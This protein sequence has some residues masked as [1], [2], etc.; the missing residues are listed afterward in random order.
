MRTAEEVVNEIHS[1][2]GDGD[3]QGLR[4][5]AALLETLQAW[6]VCPVIHAAGTN[7]KGSVCAMLNSVLTAAGYRTGMYTSPFLQTYSER[8]RLNGKPITQEMLARYG[9]ETLDAAEKLKREK[10]YHCTPFE[11]GTALAFNTFRAE[12]AELIISETGMGGRLDPTNAVPNPAVCAI[13]AIGMDHM[14]YLGHTL[15]AIA[16]E[17]AGIIKHGVPVVCYPPEEKEV[18]NVLTARAEKENAPLKIPEKGQVRIREANAR[19]TIADYDTGCRRWEN[20]K[21]SLP[22]EHQTVNALVVLCVLEE[23]EKQGI[24]VPKE[25]VISGLGNTFWPGRLEWSG[26]VIM[27]GAHNA[28]GIAAFCR[29]VQ[30][31]LSGKKKV[32]LT[33]VLKEKLSEGMLNGLASVTDTA[34]TV[35]PDS[36]RAMDA[37]ELAGLLRGKGMEALAANTLKEGLETAR[38]LAGEN[39]LI[40][41]TGSLYFIGALRSE[42]GMEP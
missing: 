25:A 23:L 42:M 21:I 33:G 24:S 22:G 29:Y 27:D 16:G 31:Q 6:P 30:E 34:V 4:N 17:K 14:Q 37:E 7:G 12:N 1:A 5:T 10:D 26:N 13:T 40:L 41:A 11:L 28:Q 35:T 36:P 15:S 39:G 20:L 32:L 19:Y 2:L 9:N 18:R 38:T 8:I 3:K